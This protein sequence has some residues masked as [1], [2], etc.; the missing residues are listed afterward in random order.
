M[1]I[2]IYGK[3]ACP[4]CDDVKELFK[5]AG[6]NYDYHDYGH[7]LGKKDLAIEL[8]S[9][10]AY[11]DFGND[12][13]LPFVVI[14]NTKAYTGDDLDKLEIAIESIKRMHLFKFD[15]DCEIDNARL[16]P[17]LDRDGNCPCKPVDVRCPCHKAIA[18][19]KAKGRCGCRLFV[20]EMAK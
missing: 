17:V 9:E 13:D 1:E 18:D 14:A 16:K 3:D 6:F 8:L 7:H 12:I 11:F 2:R 15:N 19:I 5:D 20:K 10:I 4:A